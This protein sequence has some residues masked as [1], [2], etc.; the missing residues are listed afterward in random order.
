MFDLSDKRSKRRKTILGYAQ[1]DAQH[2]VLLAAMDFEWTCRRAILALSKTPTV[3]I[4]DKFINGYEAFDGLLKAWKEEV[5]TSLDGA[6]NLPDLLNKKIAWSWVSD[7][8]MC[9]NII[10]H[11]TETRVSDKEC[12]WAVFVLEKACDVIASYVTECGKDLFVRIS[13]PRS[14]KELADVSDGGKKMIAWRA[15]V[16]QLVAKFGEGH[17]IKTGEVF[18]A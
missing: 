6:A 13:R 7:A 8:M 9:R 18:K 17:W 2:G 1:M 12:R 5:L 16:G 10:V 11:G 14:K 4:Y 3:I 15:R